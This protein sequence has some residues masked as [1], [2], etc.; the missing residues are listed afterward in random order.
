MKKYLISIE[1]KNSARLEA[2]FAQ[3]TFNKYKE[4]FKSFGIKGVEVSTADYFKL[5][6]AGRVR[7]LSPAEL[8]CSL[9]HV[10]ALKDFL[11]SDEQYACVFED[12]AVS[13]KDIDL[14]LLIKDIKT[15]NLPNCLFFSLGGIQLKLNNSVRG[16]LQ[17]ES[18]QDLP[19]LKIHPHYYKKLSYA[20]AYVV[21]REMAQLLLKFHEQPKV[22]DIWEELYQYHPN[23]HFYATFIFDHPEID[24]CRAGQSYLQNERDAILSTKQRKRTVLDI[25]KNSLLKRI[26]K[27]LLRT[28]P[29]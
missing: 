21:D 26:Y 25:F 2:F 15:M 10:S 24:D 14:E 5:A 11:A 18:L 9:S 23:P 6:V 28:Y 16:I 12:D 19:V 27:F 17:K 22:Y 29:Y 7:P 1:D 13:T 20:Y 4:S 8:G 3:E